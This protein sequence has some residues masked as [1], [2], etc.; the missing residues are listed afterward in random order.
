MKSLALE[1]EENINIIDKL[2]DEIK[3]YKAR[4]ESEALNL[5]ETKEEEKN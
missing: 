3:D 1:C 2:K 5:I 4:I